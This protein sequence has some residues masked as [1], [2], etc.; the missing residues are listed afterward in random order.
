[1]KGEKNRQKWENDIFETFF[2][3]NGDM[4]SAEVEMRLITE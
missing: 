4:S 2:G 1:M 3:D